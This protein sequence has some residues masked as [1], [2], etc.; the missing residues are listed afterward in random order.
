VEKVTA[1]SAFQGHGYAI[2]A[3]T[4]RTAQMKLSAMKVAMVIGS[5]VK[6]VIRVF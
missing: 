5:G 3:E 1:I 4:V 6:S 2:T